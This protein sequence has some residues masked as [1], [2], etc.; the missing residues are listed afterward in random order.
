MTLNEAGAV[1]LEL[2]ASCSAKERGITRPVKTCQGKT[3]FDEHML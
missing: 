1:L 3:N 2:C